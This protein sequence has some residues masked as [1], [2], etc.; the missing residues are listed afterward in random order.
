MC[1][2]LNSVQIPLWTIVT[3][4]NLAEAKYSCTVQIP[5]WTIVTD[6]SKKLRLPA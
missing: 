6:D 2:G 4:F 5:L 1:S 3:L